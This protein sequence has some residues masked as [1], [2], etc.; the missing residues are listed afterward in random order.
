[1]RTKVLVCIARG[2]EGGGGEGAGLKTR[3]ST[4]SPTASCIKWR[5][6]QQVISGVGVVN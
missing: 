1:M 4:I 2:G 3:L 6:Q 5:M